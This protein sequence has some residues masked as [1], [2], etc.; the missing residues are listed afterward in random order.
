LRFCFACAVTRRTLRSARSPLQRKSTSQLPDCIM[1]RS[2]HFESSACLLMH[3]TERT[4]PAHA[5]SSGYE[6]PSERMP[7]LAHAHSALHRACQHSISRVSSCKHHPAA[8]GMCAVT[9]HRDRL[10]PAHRMRMQAIGR[11][12]ALH[13]S[14]VCACNSTTALHAR[15]TRVTPRTAS[16]ASRRIRSPLRRS[17]A[18]APFCEHFSCPHLLTFAT[19]PLLLPHLPP[20]LHTRRR[21]SADASAAQLASSRRQS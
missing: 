11:V 14:L 3:T 10:R 8:M 9:Q 6:P 19:A 20:S 5:Q 17:A 16:A 4:S 15:T 13:V 12:D 21:R 18:K 7:S 2:L 1:Q